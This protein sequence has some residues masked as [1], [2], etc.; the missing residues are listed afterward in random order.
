MNDWAVGV[1]KIIGTQQNMLI[2][3]AEELAGMRE[4]IKV[5]Q[6]NLEELP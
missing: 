5:L 6:Q 2:Q 1:L 4:T 3:V